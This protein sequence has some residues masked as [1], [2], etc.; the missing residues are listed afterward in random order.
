L[1]LEPENRN[2]E[3][4][5]DNPACHPAGENRELFPPIVVE[6]DILLYPVALMEHQN[7]N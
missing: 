4:R 5:T 3:S 7:L 6:N 1:N 2:L